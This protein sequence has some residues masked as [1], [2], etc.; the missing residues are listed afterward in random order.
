[1]CHED[2][3]P[4]LFKEN[5]RG[6][7][8]KV[9]ENLERRLERINQT[10][11]PLHTACKHC[12]VEAVVY[13]LDHSGLRLPKC[14]HAVTVITIVGI[15]CVTLIASLVDPNTTNSD[16][17]TALHVVL[18]S[19]GRPTD[20]KII[21]DLLSHK[22]NANVCNAVGNTPLLNACRC[23]H[24]KFPQPLKHLLR[25]HHRFAQQLPLFGDRKNLT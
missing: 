24:T 1:M 22:A 4:Q 8:K 2:D 14:Q 13:L 21:Q 11:I 25:Q 16:G 5:F 19:V 17:D 20:Q 7:Y 15:I 9:K 6:P 23:A 12:D 18:G 10:Q 3:G